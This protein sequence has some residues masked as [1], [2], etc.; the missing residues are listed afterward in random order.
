VQPLNRET[1]PGLLLPLAYIYKRHPNAVVAVFPSDQ[2]ILE[3][4]HLMRHIQLAHAAVER[5]PSRLVLLGITPDY[6]EKDYGYIVP[7]VAL[8]GADCGIRNVETFIEKPDVPFARELISHGGLWNTMLIV[9]NVATLLAWVKEI[10]PELHGHFARIYDAIGTRGESSSIRAVY[11]ALRPV[12]FSKELL[13]PIARRYPGG[14]A[15]LP[16]TDVTWSDWGTERRIVNSLK[17]IG[18]RPWEPAPVPALQRTG[19]GRSKREG[20]DRRAA[21][22]L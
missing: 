13:E 6:E 5:E 15:V 14:L 8:D 17:N 18:R 19:R 11:D 7:G 10:A 4:D 12:N 2:F 22:T 3:T 1:G 16:I 21:Y 9:F 20:V